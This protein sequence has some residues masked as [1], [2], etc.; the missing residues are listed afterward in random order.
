MAGDAL[1]T[2][3]A[4]PIDLIGPLRP[5]LSPRAVPLAVHDGANLLTPSSTSRAPR[6]F[7]V[8]EDVN[9]DASYRA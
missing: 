4:P 2:V 9:T 7:S 8:G 3:I 5:G 1:A 6:R